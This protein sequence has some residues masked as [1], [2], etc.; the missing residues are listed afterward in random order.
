MALQFIFG[1]S[2]AGKSEYGFRSVIEQS[3]R[4]PERRYLVVV[5]EQFTMETQK[6]LAS[7]HPARGILNIDVLSFQRLA[8]RIFEETGGELRP[9]LSET[10]KTLVLQRIAQEQEKNLKVLGQNLKKQGAVAKMKSLVS[11][12]MQYQVQETDLQ[13]WEEQAK[14]K[15]LLALKLADIRC[16]YH[17]FEEYLKDSYVTP[18]EILEVLTRKLEQSEKI[19]NS[20]ILFDGFVGFTPSQL[21]VMKELMVLCPKMTVTVMLDEREDPLSKDGPQK[22]F[23]LSK[24]MIGQLLESASQVRCELLPEIVVRRGEYGRFQKGSALDFL[25]QNLYRYQRKTWAGKPEGISIRV[26]TN[27]QEELRLVAE[28]IHEL[29]RTKGY[30]YRDI[31]VLSGDLSV[32]SGYVRQIFRE[33]GIPCFLDEKH[34]VMMNPFVEFLRASLDL[35]VQDFSSDAV[36]RYLR[37]SM[38]GLTKEETDEL[39]NYVIALGIRGFRRYQETWT[40]C[41]RGMKEERLVFINKLRERF[42]S[43]V[44]AFAQSMKRRGGTVLFRTRTL[45]D[46]IVKNRCQQKLEEYRVNFEAQ[47]EAAMAREY[48]Q[49]YGI[50]MELLDKL[51]EVLGEETIA[52]Q[53]YQEL[54]EAGFQEAQV[55]VIPPAADQVLVGDNERSRLKNI[56]VLFFVG[57]N[58]GL[59]PKHSGA[60][61][62]LSE[63]DREALN[64]KD[65]KLSPTAREEMYMQRFYLY[66]N[67]TR[68]SK[69]LYLSYCRTNAKGESLLPSY[70]VGSF[71]KLFPEL[72]VEEADSETE[73][74]KTPSSALPM[75]LK[76]LHKAVEQ[77]ADPEFLELLRWYKNNAA[78][79]IDPDTY[80]DAAFFRN[81]EDVIGK[82]AAH[83]LYGQVLTNS[84]TRLERFAACAFAHFMEYG[85]RLQER[86]Q[87]E[88]KAS[89]LGSV[90]HEA[91]ERFARILEKEGLDWKELEEDDRERL[92]DESV[93]AV[94]GDYGNTILQSSSRNQY[95]ITRVKR[96]LR[97]TVWALQEQLEKGSFSPGAFEVSFA[98]EDSLDAINI[99]LSEKEKLKLRGRI[100]RMDV[101]EKE[102]TV[103]VKIIDYKSGNTSLDL[104]ALYYGLQLQL[105][106]YMDAA[107]ELEERKHPKKTVEPAGIFYYHIGDPMLEK[108]EGETDEAW[109]RRMLAALK[110]DGLVNA[111][112]EV[113]ALMDRTIGAGAASDVIPVGYKKD[114]SFSSYSKVASKEDF[115]VLRKYAEKKIRKIGRAILDGAANA[116]PYQLGTRNACTFCPYGGICGF[117]QRLPGYQYR[118]LKSLDDFELF[119]NMREETK[120]SEKENG[121]WE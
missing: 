43:E 14:D 31:A 55:A 38:G 108:K 105:V 18:E 109:S 64:R 10:G 99:A 26:M 23:Y 100:D 80:I 33:A 79:G 62:I 68:P 120:E 110:M 30:R 112:P 63:P 98:M 42:L 9:V 2:G 74:P 118:K 6:K 28:K 116:E 48:A 103:Y 85:L 90:M 93:D 29:V 46:F 115:S 86:V 52:L 1:N 88:F 95:M 58:E 89:D 77:E 78:S 13:E 60:G 70:L 37:C 96:I 36:F 71:R 41:Y 27:P 54:L 20:E 83:A 67:L 35:I 111:D 121:T 12:L 57:V 4:H 21:K 22:L 66:L 11:E 107:L 24:K 40:R 76:G 87:Y 32:Y 25:E 8:Y 61:G 81:P 75:F 101:C 84:A 65:V 94:M 15:P 117:D 97:R 19:R 106:V 17:A 59:I 72:E 44:E 69:E 119:A 82:S 47:K 34:T 16:I 56:S 45:Y 50:V 51:V 91:L 5:P 3:L 92:I 104:V 113:I 53:D 7:M 102:D 114:G 49:I 39:E 73:I